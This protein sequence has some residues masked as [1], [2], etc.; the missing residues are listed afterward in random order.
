MARTSDEVIEDL[1]QEVA[2]EK[3]RRTELQQRIDETREVL[4]AGEGEDVVAA[5]HRVKREALV[6]RETSPPAGS[7][8]EIPQLTGGAHQVPGAELPD[9]A[10]AETDAELRRMEPV[11]GYI[12]TL[13]WIEEGDIRPY[14]EGNLRAFW[15]WILENAPSNEELYD[16]ELAQVLHHIDRLRPKGELTHA[17]VAYVHVLRDSLARKEHRISD[18][19]RLLIREE[20][21]AIR[22]EMHAM[23]AL[24]EAQE[25]RRRV[26]EK[27]AQAR[28]VR[29]Q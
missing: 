6:G 14:V 3:R 22:D 9:P 24:R 18:E 25:R 15:T 26:A 16:H 12:R 8:G 11:E 2:R 21:E 20:A 23:D 29:A 28:Q 7:T 4:G 19:E 17:A 1:R 10:K 27:L 13:S 5:A